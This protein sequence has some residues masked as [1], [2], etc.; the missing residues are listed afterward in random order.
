[1]IFTSPAVG[2]NIPFKLILNFEVRQETKSP[3]HAH[4][5]AH[6]RAIK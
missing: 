2:P 3:L 5:Y 6:A 1:M 4:F